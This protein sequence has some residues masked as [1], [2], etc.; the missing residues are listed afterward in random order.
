MPD[1]A[2]NVEV[3]KKA[4]KRWHETRGGSADEWLEICSDRIA[5]GSLAQGPEGARYLTS[6]Q[7]RDALKDYFKGL[8]NDWEMIEFVAEHFVAQ[9][10]RVVMLGRCAWRHRRTRKEVESPLVHVWRFRDGK[11]TEYY[12][13]YDTA[14][15]FAAARADP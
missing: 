4:Y 2:R 11:A 3:L 9:D 7:S 10:D 13:L 15:A 5:F 12:E 14:K 8:S 1:E 6:Y